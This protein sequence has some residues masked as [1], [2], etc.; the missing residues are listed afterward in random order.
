MGG[1]RREQGR[2]CGWYVNKRKISIKRE[3][4]PKIQKSFMVWTESN[5]Y[6]ISPPHVKYFML[7]FRPDYYQLK[8]FIQTPWLFKPEMLCLILQLRVMSLCPLGNYLCFYFLFFLRLTFSGTSCIPILFK[9]FCN[10]KVLN[11]KIVKI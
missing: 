9:P 5:N 10:I 1:R 4:K 2:N 11:D 7:Y 3:G 6:C 8:T